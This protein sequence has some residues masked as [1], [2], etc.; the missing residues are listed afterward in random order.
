[1][2]E[3]RPV[4]AGEPLPRAISETQLSL[5]IQQANEFDQD[6]ILLMAH[7]GPRTCEIHA[8][9]WQ[10]IDPKRC[11][12]RIEASKGLRSRVVFLSAPALQV[13]QRLTAKS[14]GSHLYI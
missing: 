12:I 4:K 3:V 6:C 13:L 14:I 1:M 10:D 8:L 7:S 2:L 11:K 5:L 9:R